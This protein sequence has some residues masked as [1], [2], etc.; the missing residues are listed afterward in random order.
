MVLPFRYQHAHCH[1]FMH[2]SNTH[3]ELLLLHLGMH[4]MKILLHVH[5]E[6]SCIYT[7]WSNSCINTCQCVHP[8][9][10]QSGLYNLMYI[11]KS[12]YFYWH[13]SVSFISLC[14]PVSPC[15]WWAVFSVL[16]WE[17]FLLQRRRWNNL[18]SLYSEFPTS[19]EYL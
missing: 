13:V 1:E 10:L 14:A 6:L 4:K 11:I 7:A 3:N 16:E 2:E 15:R 9:C 5:F 18:F 12:Y 8:F 19:P 17:F